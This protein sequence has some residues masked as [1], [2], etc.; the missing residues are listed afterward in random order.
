M[1][2]AVE[3]QDS[4]QLFAE[5]VSDISWEDMVDAMRADPAA[6]IES[7]GGCNGVCDCDNTD[8]LTGLSTDEIIWSGID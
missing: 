5:D 7:C 4:A 2:E 8:T 6:Q 1:E 3:I